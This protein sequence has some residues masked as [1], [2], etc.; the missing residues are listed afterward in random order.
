MYV[1]SLRRVWPNHF[2]FILF[3]RVDMGSFKPMGYSNLIHSDYQKQATALTLP[4]NKALNTY[5]TNPKNGISRLSP[6][7]TYGVLMS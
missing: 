1:S 4:V 7:A 5:R 2:H 6:A 3:N